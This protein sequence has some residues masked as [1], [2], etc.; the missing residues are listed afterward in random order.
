MSEPKEISEE[1][2]LEIANKLF[3]AYSKDKPDV[4]VS[5]HATDEQK[6]ALSDWIKAKYGE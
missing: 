2:L 1:E 6:K 4:Y 3:A 5:H